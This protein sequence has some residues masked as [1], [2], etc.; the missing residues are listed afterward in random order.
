MGGIARASFAGL[1]QSARRHPVQGAIGHLKNLR[2]RSEGW[3]RTAWEKLAVVT[4]P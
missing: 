4:I 2:K 1:F 3:A